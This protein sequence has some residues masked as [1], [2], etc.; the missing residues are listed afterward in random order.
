MS[1]FALQ[2][3]LPASPA[4]PRRAAETV[5]HH[6]VG[7]IVRNEVAGVQEFLGFT[8][9]RGLALDVGAEDVPCGD[10]DNAKTRGDFSA[11]VPLWQSPGG[12]TWK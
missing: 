9:E 4:R 3:S 8:A 7:D 2:G 1:P 10:G 12:Q 5:T 6:V 11:W